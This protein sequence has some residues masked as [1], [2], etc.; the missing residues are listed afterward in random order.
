VPLSIAPGIMPKWRDTEFICHLFD[1]LAKYLARMA[2]YPRQAGTP[3]PAV[4]QKRRRQQSCCRVAKRTA[5]ASG[6]RTCAAHRRGR[7]TRPPQSCQYLQSGIIRAIL[8]DTSVVH[9]SALTS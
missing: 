7:Y 6:K 1:Y 8:S 3:Q 4:S 2:R 9:A 5:T